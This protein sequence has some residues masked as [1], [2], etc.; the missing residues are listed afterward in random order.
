MTLSS[1]IYCLH[2]SSLPVRFL[3]GI[4]YQDLYLHLFYL[5]FSFPLYF[6]WLVSFFLWPFQRF[7]HLVLMISRGKSFALYPLIHSQDSNHRLSACEQLLKYILLKSAL[8]SRFLLALNQ[9]LSARC[10]KAPQTQYIWSSFVISPKPSFS[11][12]SSLGWWNCYPPT[13]SK[14]RIILDF[15]S[16]TPVSFSLENF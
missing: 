4:L 3:C 8:R 1:I 6:S 13:M 5:S 15:H 14:H 2:F 12:I 16:P 10:P 11:C 9:I 7:L